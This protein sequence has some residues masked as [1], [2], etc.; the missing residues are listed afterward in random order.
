[1][2]SSSTPL[3][4]FLF[5]SSILIVSV[6]SANHKKTPFQP[7]GLVFPII[8]DQSTNYTQHITRIYQ[9]TPLVPISLTFDLG[10]EN[11]WVDCGNRFYNSSSYEPAH[12]GSKICKT[13][14]GLSCRDCWDG[15]RPGCNKNTCTTEIRNQI[16][17]H[18]TLG[19][20][21]QDNFAVQ[22]F[23]GSSP[24]PGP[25]VS[26][27]RLVFAC[28]E[29]PQL[30]GTPDLVHGFA[31]FGRG[32]L[33]IS[34]VLSKAFNLPN[35]FAVCLSN[36]TRSTGVIFFGEKPYLV[37]PNRDLSVYLLY[38]PL[39]I[40]PFRIPGVKW[41]DCSSLDYWVQVT[42]IEIS[43][44]K[45]PLNTTLLTI[46][47]E[48]F[49]GTKISTIHPYTIMSTKIYKA[50]IK[51]YLKE[52]AHGKRVKAVEPFELCFKDLPDTQVGPSSPFIDIIFH[53]EFIGWRIYGANSMVKVGKNVFCLG[54]LDGGENNEI[55][56]IIGAHQMENNL[57]QFDL[58]NSRLGFTST[59]LREQTSC[60]KFNFRG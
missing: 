52:F 37:N 44:K 18:L 2:A 24:S 28:G 59:L 33:G 6:S 57:F 55:G 38:T 30:E 58:V 46:D 53:S 45:V 54:F 60:S 7:Y 12:C 56:M 4:L 15:P 50:F 32:N 16:T 19:E 27:P 14:G 25:L 43:G 48:G 35:K 29:A 51:A 17:D 23:N 21:A 49:G 22:S 42:S 11:L 3:I 26:V 34:S 31:G 13:F 1:M 40:K 41:K 20:L 47:K 5:Y 36:S 9:R 10:G 39:I 8:K